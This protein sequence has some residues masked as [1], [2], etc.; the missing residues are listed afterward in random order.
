[1]TV[2]DLVFGKLAPVGVALP[3]GADACLR[4]AES[5]RQDLAWLGRRTDHRDLLVCQFALVFAQMSC[6]LAGFKMRRIDAP[7]VLASVMDVTPLR[8]WP[9]V[10]LIAPAVGGY[11]NPP[12]AMHG[13]ALR[14]A[15]TPLPAS[16]RTNVPQ[17]LTRLVRSALVALCGSDALSGAIPLQLG[18][19][20]HTPFPT[21]RTCHFDPLVRL[22]GMASADRTRLTAK[23]LL[24]VLGL[25]RITA[26]NALFVHCSAF[27][28]RMREV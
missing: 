4:D 18:G 8:Y 21:N 19:Q 25:K 5:T 6:W 16:V 10:L 24:A 1:M 28:V 26:V 7:A 20:S 17:R 14:L 15:A 22:R 2:A 3:N 11:T 13:I 27:G 23:A 9:D 12:V